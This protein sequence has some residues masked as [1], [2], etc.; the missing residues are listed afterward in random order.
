MIFCILYLGIAPSILI[1]NF[2]DVLLGGYY[3][4][5]QSHSKLR[6]V[7]LNSVL[8]SG[9]IQRQDGDHSGEEQW[10]WLIEVLSKAKKKNERVSDNIFRWTLIILLRFLVT[11]KIFSCHKHEYPYEGCIIA[12]LRSGTLAFFLNDTSEA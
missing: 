11:S 1:I 6:I 4:I 12:P 2:F 9:G 8:W 10:K 7:V 5:E 3:T